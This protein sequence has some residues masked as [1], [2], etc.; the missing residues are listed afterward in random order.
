MVKFQRSLG[1]ESHQ[2]SIGLLEV[3]IPPTPES[4][5]QYSLR[6]QPKYPSFSIKLHH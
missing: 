1:I 4:L 3:Q 6:Y 5:E 2:N